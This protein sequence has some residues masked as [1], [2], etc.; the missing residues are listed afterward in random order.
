[1]FAS[2]TQ[3]RD[4]ACPNPQCKVLRFRMQEC[5]HHKEAPLLTVW[6]EKLRQ[7]HWVF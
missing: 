5:S 6:R 2:V 7:R 3:Q 4:K 1:M